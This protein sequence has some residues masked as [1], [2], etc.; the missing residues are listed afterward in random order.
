MSVFNSQVALLIID[1]IDEYVS[2][3]GIMYVSGAEGIVSAIG[4]IADEA[5]REG[6]PVIYICDSHEAYDAGTTAWRRQ[7]VGTVPAEEIIPE[8]TPLP[9]DFIIRKHP[10]SSF[11][12]KDLD[13]LLKE[14]GITKLV[15]TGTAV[16]IWIHFAARE[17]HMKGY[18]IAIP[19]KCVVA[20]SEGEEE[21]TIKQMQ[22][23]F[24]AEII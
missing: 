24:N 7:P 21:N 5:R 6:S 11:F 9:D 1:M 4:Q 15:F 10:Y 16:D 14:L 13:I 8:L 20:L 19:E 2:E 18:R 12:G 3:D 22:R 23:L 17:A